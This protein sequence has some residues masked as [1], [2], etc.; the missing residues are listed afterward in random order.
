MH[1]H[2]KFD[3]PWTLKPHIH[4]HNMTRC[5]ATINKDLY[6][7]MFSPALSHQLTLTHTLRDASSSHSAHAQKRSVSSLPVQIGGGIRLLLLLSV[8]A[9]TRHTHAL[10][11]AHRHKIPLPTYTERGKYDSRCHTYVVINLSVYPSSCY[12]CT[13][14]TVWGQFTPVGDSMWIFAVAIRYNPRCECSKNGHC[15]F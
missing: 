7:F 13:T 12:C 5:L 14:L 6:T 15:N 1:T 8:N 3:I 4:T 9:L 2:I 10:A 11:G